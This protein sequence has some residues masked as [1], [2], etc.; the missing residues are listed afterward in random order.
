MPVLIACYLLDA[1]SEELQQRIDEFDPSLFEGEPD[2]PEAP[3][4]IDALLEGVL[5]GTEG[6]MGGRGEGTQQ[7]FVTDILPPGEDD[8]DGDRV[9]LEGTPPG[10]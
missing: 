6:Y 1:Q 5:P 3:G 8:G 10:R 2:P 4:V 9:E 7:D